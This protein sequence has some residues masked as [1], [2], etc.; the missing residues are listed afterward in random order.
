MDARLRV[1][2]HLLGEAAT[3]PA[4]PATVLTPQHWQHDKAL[5]VK[6]VQLRCEELGL[7]LCEAEARLQQRLEEQAQRSQVL[8]QLMS[9]LAAACRGSGAWWGLGIG[10]E[11]RALQ[12]LLCVLCTARQDGQVRSGTS[13]LCAQPWHM[14]ACHE[15][16]PG[17]SCLAEAV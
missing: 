16:D 1:C 7:Q 11:L 6:L 10:A 12:C 2:E 9:R 14:S 13:S 15:A 4:S 17:I 5:L 3:P 8:G